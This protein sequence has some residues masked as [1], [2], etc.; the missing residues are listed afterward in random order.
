MNLGTLA[1]D[2]GC[3]PLEYG[4]YPPQ[5][6]SRTVVIGIRSLVGFGTMFRSP[7]PSSDLP[8]IQIM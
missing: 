8:P 7:S 4:A 1:G 5:S 3:F 2:L 6:D